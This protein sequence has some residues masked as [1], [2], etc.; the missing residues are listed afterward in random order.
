MVIRLL[1]LILLF[2]QISG[3]WH[4]WH[5]P[6]A[7]IDELSFPRNVQLMIGVTWCGL[8]LWGI[9]TLDRAI[10]IVFGF[11]VYSIIRPLL[12]AQTDYD[13]NRMPFLM[14]CL[15]IILCIGIVQFWAAKS[16]EP[17]PDD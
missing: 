2:V 1:C 11:L 14:V 17:F 15:I 3:L 5:L 13:A 10:W 16:K 7:F 4:L 8:F 9:V 6:P 12:F